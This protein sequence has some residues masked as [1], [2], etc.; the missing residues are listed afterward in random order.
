MA[1]AELGAEGEEECGF[2][3]CQRTAVGE[4]P[5]YFGRV[6]TETACAD[7]GG[8]VFYC[9]MHLDMLLFSV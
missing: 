1:V 5:V 6:R 7:E 4:Q 3:K 2:G 8:Y 9:V